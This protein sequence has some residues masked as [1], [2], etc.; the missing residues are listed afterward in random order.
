MI[1]DRNKLSTKE[2]EIAKTQSAQYFALSSLCPTGV[3]KLYRKSVFTHFMI[4]FFFFKSNQIRL[5][6]IFFS[7][8]ICSVKKALKKNYKYEK[9]I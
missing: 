8:R 2:L 3:I 6:G 9:F 1:L 7:L 4:L 5:S